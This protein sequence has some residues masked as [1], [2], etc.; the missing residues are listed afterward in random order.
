ML[1]LGIASKKPASARIVSTGPHPQRLARLGTVQIVAFVLEVRVVRTLDISGQV[2]DDTRDAAE[3]LAAQ[4]GD[5]LTQVFELPNN[6]TQTAASDTTDWIGANWTG[7]THRFVN[8]KKGEAARLDSIHR[9]DCTAVT[10]P[11]T[12]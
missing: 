7:S 2:D 4:D 6:L 9:F 1:R 10:R 8:V 12:T 5:V 11:A 3:A